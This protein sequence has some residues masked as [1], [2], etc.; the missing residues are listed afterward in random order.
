[1]INL[2][3]IILL[4]LIK[5]TMLVIHNIYKVNDNKNGKK[6]QKTKKLNQNL[7]R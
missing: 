7:F 1:M 6:Y 2:N 4:N 3:I 5:Y